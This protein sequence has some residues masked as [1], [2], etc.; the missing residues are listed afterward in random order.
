MAGPAPLPWGRDS[1][2]PVSGR[3]LVVSLI[4]EAKEHT[5][6]LLNKDAVCAGPQDSQLNNVTGKNKTLVHKCK[7]QRKEPQMTLAGFELCRALG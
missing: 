4:L 7:G 3:L 1:R 2:R 5:Y 6:G